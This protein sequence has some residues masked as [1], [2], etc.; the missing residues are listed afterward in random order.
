MSIVGAVLFLY[1]SWSRARPKP[2][3][4]R[5]QPMKITTRCPACTAPR[6]FKWVF[7]PPRVANRTHTMVQ[8]GPGLAALPDHSKACGVRPCPDIQAGTC[9]LLACFLRKHLVEERSLGDE[10]GDGRL[11]PRPP[12]TLRTESASSSQGARARGADGACDLLRP[13]TSAPVQQRWGG[14]EGGGAAF[15]QRHPCTQPIGNTVH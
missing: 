1:G 11:S 10:A 4:G 13:R 12:G 15:I 3:W 6:I 14:R 2:G 7:H 9:W 5:D 8:N